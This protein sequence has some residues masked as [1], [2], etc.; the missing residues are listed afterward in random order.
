MVKAMG[1][2]FP[3]FVPLMK[4]ILNKFNHNFEEVTKSANPKLLVAVS[5]GIDSMVLCDLLLKSEK[6][7]SVAHC[8]FQLRGIDSDEDEKFVRNYCIQNQ[9]QFHS[10][11][12]N[13]KEFKQS[14]NFSTQMAA[15]E[16]RYNW[17]REL[18]NEFKFDYLLTAHHLND[19]LE[20]FLI[21][22][23]RGT[24]IEGLSGINLLKNNIFR[25]LYNSSKKEILQYAEENMIQ[26]R[27]DV[28]NAKIDYKRNKIRHQITPVL[29]EIHP[30]FLQNFAKTIEILKQEN[31]FIRQF[32]Q[33]TKEELFE[34]KDAVVHI[35]IQKLKK[36]EPLH[37][38]LH[39]LFF[40]YGFKH[41]PEIEK[42]MNADENGEIQSEHYRLIKNRSEF[43]L[44]EINSIESSTEFIIEEGEILENPL[45][46]KFSKSEERDF[47]ANETL[48]YEKISFPLKLRKPETG[49]VFYPIGL[50]GSKK[51]SKFFKDEKYSKLDKEN[52]WVLV[53]DQNRILYLTGKRI[54]ERFKI[55]EHTHKFL[56][57]YLC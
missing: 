44:C 46:L 53:D 28:S 52:A 6:E 55:T 34:Q 43:L 50:K 54:D 27:E 30:E 47:S 22:L 12:F 33:N 23:S 18:M 9:I 3:K 35:S 19:S 1:F 38:Y 56:N 4:N 36:L 21:N 29:E 45:Y 5:G 24:G 16:L 40:E 32:I 11:R 2:L 17:F 48:D 41:P 26:W 39:H 10:K 13:I 25:P 31:S 7:F 42:L 20:T 15:R 57:I 49:D 51:L 8:N 37:S 14:G